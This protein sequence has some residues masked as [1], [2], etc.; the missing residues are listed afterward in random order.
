M[1]TRAVCISMGGDPL[2]ADFTLSCWNKWWR[3]EVDVVYA[4]Y[5][6]HADVN[7]HV[8]YE[9]L[10]KWE[11]DPKVRIIYVPHGCGNGTPITQ[12]V[13]GSKEDSLLLLEDD[14]YVFTPGVVDSWFTVVETT[15]STVVGSP[16]YSVGEVA[17]AAQ[18]NYKL[19]Y[20]GVGDKGF[21]AWPS[22][23]VCKRSDLLQTGLDFGSTKYPK[24]EYI[25]EI[26]HTMENDDYTDTFTFAFLE[27][28]HLGKIMFEIPQNHTYPT[29]FEKD[30]KMYAQLQDGHEIK[31]LHGGSLS[32]GWGGYLN[33]NLPPVGDPFQ[34]KDI[35]TRVAFWKIVGDVTDGYDSFKSMYRAGIERLI[36]DCGLDRNRIQTK[37]NGYK[38]IMKI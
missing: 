13:L 6:N 10:R 9:F 38:R 36:I 2:L 23:F 17:I 22:F 29:D 31:Y 1:T 19:D 3:D 24:G 28:R 14:S 33:K 11:R 4:A 12:V 34:K 26:D 30:G 20:A 32:S 37:Y 21:A 7:Q 16:R 5:N 27:L 8:S 35:E 18:N 15:P 25:K